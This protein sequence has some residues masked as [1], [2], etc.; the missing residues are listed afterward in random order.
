VIEDQLGNLSQG[1][2][3]KRTPIMHGQSTMTQVQATHQ[4]PA[5]VLTEVVAQVCPPW[6][7]R[8]TCVVGP[9]MQNR[10]PTLNLCGAL[11]IRDSID[12]LAEYVPADLYGGQAFDSERGRVGVAR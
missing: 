10:Q 1:R 5:W 6:P 12:A 3:S 7:W 4:L 2:A 9:S 11:L 8:D